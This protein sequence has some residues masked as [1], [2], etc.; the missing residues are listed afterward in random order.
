MYEYPPYDGFYNNRADPSWGSADSK[1]LR[2]LPNHYADGSYQPSGKGR[3][4]PMELSLA[5][6]AGNTG[7]PSY[8]NRTALLVFFGQQV[9]EEI[10][11]AQRPGCPP[12]YFNIK[13]PKNHPIHD[14]DITKVQSMPLLRSRYDMNTG[15]SPNNPRQQLNEITPYIDG[16]LTYGVSKAWADA[17]R[18]FKDGKLASVNEN[19]EEYPEINDI[20]LPM[21]NPPPPKDHVLKK[22][23]RFWSK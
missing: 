13:I 9:V 14:P 18:S 16:G 8:K 10:L 19:G 23:N 15:K 5:L 20:R 11:D 6:M 4:N 17:L 22:I 2:R 21:A 12:E 1:L 3:P 7:E